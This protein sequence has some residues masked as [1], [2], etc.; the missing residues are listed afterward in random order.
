ML[1]FHKNKSKHINNCVIYNFNNVKINFKFVNNGGIVNIFLHGWGRDMR[2]FDDV[3]KIKNNV[4]YLL[5]DFPPFGKSG[6]P[7]NWTI[8]TYANMLISLIRHLKIKKANLIGHSFGGRVAILVAGME[9]EL[10]ENLVLVDSAGMRPK[11]KIG[12][13]FKVFK[14]KIMKKLGLNTNSFGSE[15]YKKLSSNM[16]ATFNN[17]VNTYLEENAKLLKVRTLIIFGKNDK[18][19]PIYMA[20]KLNR[21]IDNS[22]LVLIENAGHFC[23]LERKIYFCEILSDFLEG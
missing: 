14:Y 17:I 1:L 15:D 16:K 4:S 13:K 7:Q 8:F 10:I 22:K 9:K 11:R 3:V 21:L 18:E 6:E 23:F 12:V 2:D 19:T 20:K 5:I